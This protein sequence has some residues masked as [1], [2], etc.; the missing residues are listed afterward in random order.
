MDESALTRQVTSQVPTAGSS[1]SRMQGS[2]KLEAVDAIRGWAI[3][4]VMVAHVGSLFP[5]LPYPVKRVTNF[6]WY[7]V[8]LFF[9]AS[10]FTLMLSWNRMKG[11]TGT[12][13]FNFFLRRLF[14][15]APAFYLGA[16]LYVFVRPP[17]SHFDVSQLLATL[18]F[19]NAWSPDWMTTVEGRWQVVPG[20]WSV[21]VEFC[22]YFAFPLIALFVRNALQACAFALGATCLMAISPSLGV[23]LHGSAESTPGLDNF[24]FFWPPNQLVVFSL[25]L[26]LYFLVAGSN[27]MSGVRRI[28]ERSATPILVA[29]VMA[30]LLLTL[31]PIRKTALATT[32]SYPLPTHVVVSAAFAAICAALVLSPGRYR[33]VTGLPW[34]KLGEASFAAYL[35]HWTMLDVAHAVQGTLHLKSEG[36]WAIVHYSMFLAGVTASTF[37][38]SSVAHSMIEKPM[39]ALGRRLERRP[40][41][42]G[43]SLNAG[44]HGA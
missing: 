27:G 12:R 4:L 26:V 29:G 9:I 23:W 14:R 30:I 37:V 31:F 18:L 42:A 24:L 38:L 35:L 6:G 43:P 34:R 11:D 21:S 8:Q 2:I 5:E 32:V 17:A 16:L 33:L 3:F 1:G 20:S 10:A 25:G 19:V 15:I 7:G 39:I 28:F 41:F 36:W 40:A 22:F 13:T 44:K